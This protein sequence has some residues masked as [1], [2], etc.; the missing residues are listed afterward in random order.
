MSK[1]T[2]P[3][4]FPVRIVP[5]KQPHPNFLGKYP[6]NPLQAGPFPGILKR[7]QKAMAFCRMGFHTT[8]IACAA[9]EEVSPQQHGAGS[10][11]NFEI[12]GNAYDDE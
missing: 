11:W 6:Q 5:G 7:N 4:P 8:S 2:R 9:P 1:W 10:V 12:G 3:E